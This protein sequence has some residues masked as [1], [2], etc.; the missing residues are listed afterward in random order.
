[1]AGIASDLAHLAK[2]E[3]SLALAVQH[4]GRTLQT[5]WRLCHL[6]RVA[7]SCRGC[8]LARRHDAMTNY[9]RRLTASKFWKVLVP[10]LGLDLKNVLKAARL[11]STLFDN[12][13]AA[14]TLEEYFRLWNTLAALAGGDEL[15]LRVGAV[16]SAE[17]FDP[18]IFSTLCSPDLNTAMRR[19]QQYWQVLEPRVMTVDI[20]RTRTRATLEWQGQTTSVPWI[21]AMSELVIFTKL[22]RWGTRVEVRPISI[23]VPTLPTNLEPYER[24]FGCKPRQTRDYT[25]AFSVHDAT[26]PF[27]TRDD[28]M[29]RF[30]EAAFKDRQRSLATGSDHARRVRSVL[31]ESLVSGEAGIEAVARQLHVSPRSLQRSLQQEGASYR[32]ILQQVRYDLAR[33]QLSHTSAPIARIATRLGFRDS[34]TFGRWF[35]QSAGITPSEWR[36]T[37]ARRHPAA[38][39]STMTDS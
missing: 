31:R 29:W 8:D 19:L 23:G 3:T 7:L 36:A 34:D 18:P 10:D 5:P 32:S 4:D 16:L 26:R 11:P 20:G 21:P 25:I 28:A 35:A 12:P 9:A 6:F 22:V 24:F 33:H 37:Q 17:G 1:M 30:L 38:A 13:H 14:L 39:R 2:P 27:V 15:P